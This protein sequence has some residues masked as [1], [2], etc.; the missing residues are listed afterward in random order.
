MPNK[1]IANFS[2]NIPESDE[3]LILAKR[4][5]DNT[6]AVFTKGSANHYIDLRQNP[7]KSSDFSK[8]VSRKI[9]V[10]MPY[11]CIPSAYMS[12]VDRTNT[13]DI[14]KSIIKAYKYKYSN[15]FGMASAALFLASIYGKE[16]LQAASLVC[17][18]YADHCLV[19]L[20]FRDG[21]HIFIDPWFKNDEFQGAIFKLNDSKVYHKQILDI[22]TKSLQLQFALILSPIIPVS[23]WAK[24]S[25]QNEEANSLAMYALGFSILLILLVQAVYKMEELLLDPH[26]SEEAKFYNP[27]NDTDKLRGM[28]FKQLHAFADANLDI[29]NDGTLIFRNIKRTRSKSMPDL[30]QSEIPHAP[31]VSRLAYDD[32]KADDIKRVVIGMKL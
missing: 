12:A 31:V 16:N 5:L 3:K 13:F 17:I 22:L 26:F 6:K 4:V 24:V 2:H 8:I 30:Y 19:K 11:A 9:D 14:Y 7:F 27:Q 1:P 25:S 21:D 15:C 20:E 23:L 10:A 32:I 18:K 28:S 29:Y